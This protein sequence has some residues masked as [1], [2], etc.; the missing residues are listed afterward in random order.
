M[1]THVGLKA[2]PLNVHLQFL[3][4]LH[5]GDM[6]A[7]SIVHMHI[8]LAGAAALVKQYSFPGGSIQLMLSTVAVVLFPLPVLFTRFR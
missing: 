2:L 6:P 4:F 3:G 5:R 7:S 1:G 8:T